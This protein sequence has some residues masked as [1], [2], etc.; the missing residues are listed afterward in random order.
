MIQKILDLF[1]PKVV[2]DMPPRGCLDGD[3]LARAEAQL[4]YSISLHRARIKKLEQR[5]ASLEKEMREFTKNGRT[6]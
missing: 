1:T 2:G 6:H 5:V 3:E 4:V